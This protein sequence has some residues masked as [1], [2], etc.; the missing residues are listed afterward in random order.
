MGK[1]DCLPMSTRAII[2]VQLSLTEGDFYTLWAPK[3]R[4]E[5][6][7]VAGILGRRRIRPR[8]QPAAE[9]LC[10][11]ES[12]KH[13]DLVDHPKWADFRAQGEDRITRQKRITSTSSACLPIWRAARA[14]R[15][16]P[17]LPV[18]W[19]SPRRS[20]TSPSAAHRNL[21][22]VS[23]HPAQRHPRRQPL[24]RG[25]RHERVVRRG[26]RGP[27]ELEGRH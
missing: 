26:P 16:S 6:L 20:P 15:T 13:H 18:I 17:L 8:F 27:G 21:L 4:S 25:P 2:P 23:L 12:G 11:L 14:T 9:M 24:R 10:F 22:R 5:W 3:W 7:R 19:R 1:L